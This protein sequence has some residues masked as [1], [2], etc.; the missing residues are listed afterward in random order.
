MGV[1]FTH[2]TQEA[3]RLIVDFVDKNVT[4]RAEG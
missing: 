2:L 4:Y 1:G 3:E